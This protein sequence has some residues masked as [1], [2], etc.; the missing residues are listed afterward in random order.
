M[1][2]RLAVSLYTDT[3]YLVRRAEGWTVEPLGHLGT[4]PQQHKVT[5]LTLEKA[6]ARVEEILSEALC[7]R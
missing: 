1:L 4:H 7:P 6:G 5:V 2:R 3:P